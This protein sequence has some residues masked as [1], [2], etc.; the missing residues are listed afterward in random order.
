MH[1]RFLTIKQLASHSHIGVEGESPETTIRRIRYWV[2]NTDIPYY[3]GKKRG[4]LLFSLPE[5][6]DWMSKNSHLIPFPK[7][8]SGGYTLEH[9]QGS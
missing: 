8:H 6:M 5:V 9:P 1:S 2:D 7:T 4:L 3:Q